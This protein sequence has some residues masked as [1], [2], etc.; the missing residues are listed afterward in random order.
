MWMSSINDFIVRL[1]STRLAGSPRI[2]SAADPC[3]DGDAGEGEL[4]RR[5]LS[6]PRVNV[7]EEQ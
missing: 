3:A 4:G 2:S 7:L 6:E 5:L 1:N